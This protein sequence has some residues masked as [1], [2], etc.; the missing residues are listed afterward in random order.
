MILDGIDG[1]PSGINYACNPG[2][3]TFNGN[4]NGCIKLSKL[5]AADTGIYRLTLNITANVTAFGA[6]LPMPLQDSSFVMVVGNVTAQVALKL[7][8]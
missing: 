4:S 2:T 7:L 3:C 6:P 8:Q 5:V 1:L